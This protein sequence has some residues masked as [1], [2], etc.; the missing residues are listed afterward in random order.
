M[1]SVNVLDIA[2]SMLASRTILLCLFFIFSVVLNSFF[3]IPAVMK[4]AK[5]NLHL[6]FLQVKEAIDIPPFA[7]DEAVKDLSKYLKAAIY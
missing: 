4:K 6:L 2:L 1:L 7:A 3:K 5:Q